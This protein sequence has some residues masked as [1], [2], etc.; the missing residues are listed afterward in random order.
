MKRMGRLTRNELFA[1]IEALEEQRKNGNKLYT[2]E[3]VFG[4]E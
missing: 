1:I 3:E 4:E 2:M